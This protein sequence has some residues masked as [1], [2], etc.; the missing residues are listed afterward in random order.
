MSPRRGFRL[1][2]ERVGTR[3]SRFPA[4]LDHDLSGLSLRGDVA[5]IL[6]L[7]PPSGA[8]NI[9]RARMVEQH[10]SILSG[11][12]PLVRVGWGFV[13]FTVRFGFG[14]KKTQTFK[15]E[16]H[17]WIGLITYFTVILKVW[18]RIQCL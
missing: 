17:L 15:V 10:V 4:R 18:G 5:A 1:G 6:W 9:R 2:V 16:S 14:A 7:A 12:G 3:P 8:Q 13:V 11:Q